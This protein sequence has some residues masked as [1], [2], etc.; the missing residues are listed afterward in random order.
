MADLLYRVYYSS[1]AAQRTFDGYADN[2]GDTPIFEVLVIVQ[3]D[4][5]HNRRLVSGKDFY[6]W[7]GGALGW[8][9]VDRW[10][11][12]QYMARP[13]LEKRFLVGVM[14]ETFAEAMQQARTDPAFKPQTAL[15]VF[16]DKAFFER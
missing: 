9:A 2:I 4:K 16:E 11:M 10:G 13:G 6:I 3:R 12:M 5:D 1:H 7:E 14:C 15:H 8:V